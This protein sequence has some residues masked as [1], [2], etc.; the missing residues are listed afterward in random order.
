MKLFKQI[1]ACVDGVSVLST[2]PPASTSAYWVRLPSGLVWLKL[3]F[4]SVALV[5]AYSCREVSS[6]KEFS[7]FDWRNWFNCAINSCSNLVAKSESLMFVYSLLGF[8]FVVSLCLIKL[9][10]L[11]LWV[12]VSS[13]VLL[14]IADVLEVSG[15]ETL[16]V[17]SELIHLLV[18][19]LYHV[20][21]RLS[22]FSA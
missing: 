14:V 10:E 11:A 18:P 21:P 7:P 13:D 12:F 19:T 15:S 2:A 20:L 8:V 3:V 1:F 5:L 6:V 9:L 17:N 16:W 22:F 4:A